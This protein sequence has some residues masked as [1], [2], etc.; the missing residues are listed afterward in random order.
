MLT[1]RLRGSYVADV[2]AGYIEW[3]TRADYIRSK[4][5]V[6][7]NFGLMGHIESLT[8]YAQAH[9]RA[10]PLV[11]P[12]YASK[13]PV[14]WYTPRALATP[15]GFRALLRNEVV[16]RISAIDYAAKDSSRD[17]R[18]SHTYSLICTFF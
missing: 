17:V 15:S 10:C 3:L 2:D 1:G 11:F 8:P 4:P 12:S 14:L 6:L 16:K 7:R 5:M 9:L 13:R 18:S